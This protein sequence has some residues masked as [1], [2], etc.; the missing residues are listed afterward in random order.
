MEN[1]PQ[2]PRRS[3]RV[4]NSSINYL[5]NEWVNLVFKLKEESEN[6]SIFGD[7]TLYVP[8]PKGI[9]AVM[10]WKDRDPK[11]FCLW[12]KAIK[13][14]VKNLI[15]KNTF[16]TNSVPDKGVPVIPTTL[17]NKVKLLS[18]GSWDKAK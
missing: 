13:A 18:D 3:A 4:R 12:S 15:E 17:I 2:E 10:R 8:E 1:S 6:W 16:C 7:P 11:A 14:E 5:G 9:K